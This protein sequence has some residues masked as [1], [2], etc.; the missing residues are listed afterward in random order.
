MMAGLFGVIIFS[1]RGLDICNQGY[2]VW[3]SLDSFY[4]QFPVAY[5]VAFIIFIFFV[6]CIL[7]SYFSGYLHILLRLNDAAQSNTITNIFP[8]K[9]CL[10]CIGFCML[11]LPLGLALIMIKNT[12]AFDAFRWNEGAAFAAALVTADV[13]FVNFILLYYY[14]KLLYVYAL[15][16]YF[17]A[18]VV[19]RNLETPMLDDKVHEL[20]LEA[21]RYVVLFGSVII[22]DTIVGVIAY[23]ALLV[24]GIKWKGRI[25]KMK[26]NV[27]ILLKLLQCNLLY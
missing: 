24:M 25:P 3:L 10:Y 15:R 27:N 13:L 20:M 2:C 11:F 9:Y 6:I 8:C 18:S 26:L 17:R 4:F 21:T 22:V 7:I 19:I 5:Q 14:I 16:Y 12:V 1:L 23:I